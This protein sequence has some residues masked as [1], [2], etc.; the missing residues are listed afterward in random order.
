MS[1]QEPMQ[2]DTFTGN[3]QNP[4]FKAMNAYLPKEKKGEMIPGE[5]DIILQFVL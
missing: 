3:P 1:N 4:E 2:T 5:Q